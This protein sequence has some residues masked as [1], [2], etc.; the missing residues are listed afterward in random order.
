MPKL[1]YIVLKLKYDVCFMRKSV[2]NMVHQITLHQK[3]G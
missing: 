2:P 3:H 1:I